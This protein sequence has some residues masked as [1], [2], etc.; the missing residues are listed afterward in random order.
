MPTR[1]GTPPALSAIIFVC[2]IPLETN[3][4]QKLVAFAEQDK[5]FGARSKMREGS[6]NSSAYINFVSDDLLAIQLTPE[7]KKKNQ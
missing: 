1:H 5:L 4:L 2:F 3:S 6:S 7:L